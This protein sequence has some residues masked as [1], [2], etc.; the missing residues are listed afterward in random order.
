M[1]QKPQNVSGLLLTDRNTPFWFIFA[2]DSEGLWLILN[3]ILPLCFY[4]NQ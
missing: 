1:F 4:Y 2:G 3:Y